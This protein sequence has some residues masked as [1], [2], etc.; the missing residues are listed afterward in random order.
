M[1]K[2][3][4]AAAKDM[5]KEPSESKSYK[6][7]IAKQLEFPGTPHSMDLDSPMSLLMSESSPLSSVATSLTPPPS[8][9]FRFK[10][11]WSS[12]ETNCQTRLF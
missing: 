6:S 4:V 9:A 10:G 12:K 2:E 5:E 1:T 7:A 8:V 3:K 11:P